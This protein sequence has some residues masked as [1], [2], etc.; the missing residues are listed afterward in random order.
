[1]VTIVLVLLLT[2]F[3]AGS[4]LVVARVGRPLTSSPFVTSMPAEGD[5][6]DPERMRTRAARAAA[7]LAKARPKD[8]VVIIVDTFRNRLRLYRDGELLR[9]AVCS[10]GTG[11]VLRDPRTGRQWVFD[12]PL[13]EMEI[14]NQR[15]N[16]VW[17]KP[18]WAFIEEGY[19]P[20]PRDS[21]ERFD[22]VS[23]GDYGLYMPDGYIIHGTLFK[24]LLGRRVTHGCVR[25]GDEDLEFVYKNAPIGSR[26][27]LY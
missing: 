27:Y 1:V 8:G 22:D 17:A 6:A 21:Q 23:L 25:L 11:R 13:G 12:T 26:V 3:V 10:T 18:D 16:P 5:V 2:I 9:Q 4:V 19:L 15:K 7:A 14:I 20:P 24:T